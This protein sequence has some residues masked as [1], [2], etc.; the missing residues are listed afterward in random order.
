MKYT[1]MGILDPDEHPITTRDRAAALDAFKAGTMPKV[2]TTC[3]KRG[4]DF[5]QL[6]TLIRCDGTASPIDNTQLPGRLS[7]LFD[8]KHYGTLVDYLDEFNGTLHNR[9]KRRIR[10]YKNKG[11]K[12]IMPNTIGAL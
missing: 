1:K 2:I 3:W 11:W 12:V 9:A 7:R 6:Q 8:G 4:V 5:P 10:D